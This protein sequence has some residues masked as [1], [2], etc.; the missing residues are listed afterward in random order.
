MTNLVQALVRNTS[1]TV[2]KEGIFQHR[3]R[4][5]YSCLFVSGIVGVYSI[6]ASGFYTLGTMEPFV[7]SDF[8]FNIFKVEFFV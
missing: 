1:R 5:L 6:N 7:Q 4:A 2:P 3:F 8:R